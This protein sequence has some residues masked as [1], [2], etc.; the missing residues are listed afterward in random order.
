MT[1]IDREPVRMPRK[2]T[3]PKPPRTS[4]ESGRVDAFIDSLVHP[5][6][7]AVA[8]M[9]AV[10]L[11]ADPAIGEGI[12][13]NVPSFRTSAEYFATMHL[14]MKAGIGVILH[15]GAKKTAISES[16]VAI[17]D[18]GGLLV[19]LAKDRSLVAFADASDVCARE[20]EFTALLREWIRHV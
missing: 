19:W 15:F 14:R 16:G 1:P 6:K 3:T 2:D 5:H 4:D 20:R 11:A 18:P 10:I 7:D 12:R 8:A 9:R 17:P 13:W